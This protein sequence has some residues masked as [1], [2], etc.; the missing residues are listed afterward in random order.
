MITVCL[1]LN[2]GTLTEDVFIEVTV[3]AAGGFSG[4]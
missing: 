3:F 2:R 1:E 4:C